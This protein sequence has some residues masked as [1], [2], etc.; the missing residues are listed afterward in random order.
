MWVGIRIE[1]I[2]KR[3]KDGANV[4]EDGTRDWKAPE[5]LLGPNNQTSK[6]D[7]WNVGALGGCLMTNVERVYLDIRRRNK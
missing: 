4:I 3:V 5:I 7:I 2:K 6:I 1:Y